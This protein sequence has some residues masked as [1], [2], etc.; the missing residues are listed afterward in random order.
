M[1]KNV[2]I[3]FVGITISLLTVC[4]PSERLPEEKLID[5]EVAEKT[6]GPTIIVLDSFYADVPDIDSIYNEEFFRWI[7][8]V[9]WYHSGISDVPLRSRVVSGLERFYQTMQKLAIYEDAALYPDYDKYDTIYKYDTLIIKKIYE[10]PEA[11]SY[12]AYSYHSLGNTHPWKC[13]YYCSFSKKTGAEITFEDIMDEADRK[14]IMSYVLKQLDRKKVDARDKDYLRKR[15][16]LRD[17]LEL[18]YR[19][20]PHPDFEKELVLYNP[21]ICKSGLL[22]FFLPE[23]MGTYGEGQFEVIVPYNKF[24]SKIAIK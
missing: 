23:E 15:T 9:L 19:G 6:E 24:S 17:S 12:S 11:I 13:T 3:L 21:V 22:F 10:S 14:R 16:L 20:I 7:G 4:K 8:E 5:K 18:F 2:F 1:F